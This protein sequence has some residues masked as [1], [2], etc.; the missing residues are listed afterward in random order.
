MLGLFLFSKFLKSDIICHMIRAFTLIELIVVVAIVGLIS[1]L[2]LAHYHSGEQVSDL[3]TYTQKIV[4]IL[5][6]AQSWALTGQETNGLRPGYG[7]YFSDSQT[8]F[9]FADLDD[10]RV[11]SSPLYS[12][13]SN[14]MDAALCHPDSGI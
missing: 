10:R 4:S 7:I 5:K 9:L 14:W 6:Q 1:G 3:Q 13:I 11:A 12:S 2:F 8:Y